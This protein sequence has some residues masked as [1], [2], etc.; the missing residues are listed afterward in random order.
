MI[1]ILKTI[2]Y[3]HIRY[4]R[5]VVG[6]A[7]AGLQNAYLNTRLGWLWAL[8]RP[9]IRLGVY[10]FGFAVGLRKGSPVEGYPY[11][12]YLMSGLLPWFFLST[13]FSKGATCIKKNKYLVT[14]IKF[15][16]ELIPTFNTLSD[17]VLHIILMAIG[18]VVFILMGFFPTLYWLQIPIYLLLAFLFACTWGIFSSIISTMSKDFL[19]TLRSV[20][21][22][23][24]WISGV[25]FRID[26]LDNAVV[27]RI[28]LLNPM[29]LILRG[30][31]NSL[32]YGRWFWENS[33][34]LVLVV[35]LLLLTFLACWA[36]K[37]FYRELP[38][39]I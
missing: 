37:R 19:M 1:D 38:D 35:E 3:N 25:Y 23:M 26:S 18:L 5:Q 15:P 21:T 7:K 4:W 32:I 27:R 20:S 2:I 39:F 36:Y 16:I 29:A 17:L 9:T 31:R 11:F 13:R 6:L 22:A 14:K 30:Y 33:E 12:L 34:I 8:M 10:Y 24:F 28:L